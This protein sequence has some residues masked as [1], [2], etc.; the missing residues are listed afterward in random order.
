M[1]IVYIKEY[2]NNNKIKR[3]IANIFHYIKIEEKFGKIFYSIAI[4]E[5]K[6]NVKLNKKVNEYLTDNNVN[7]VVLSSNLLKNE[8]LKN[9]LYANN[10]NILDGRKL[11]KFLSYDI[12]KKIYEYK[13]IN[14]KNRKYIYIG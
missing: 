6:K 13:E 5:K 9:A 11:F 4:N 2:E 7:T 14:L 1:S 12:L 10:I 3:S 8:E